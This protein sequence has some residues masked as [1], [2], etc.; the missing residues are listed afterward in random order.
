M[1]L[2]QPVSIANLREGDIP[3]IK[4]SL[5]ASYCSRYSC[6]GSR[7]GKQTSLTAKKLEACVEFTE[8]KRIAR[9]L[10]LEKFKLGHRHKT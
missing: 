2:L 6:P 9:E 8:F 5:T 10:I 7:A 4:V 3:W 1:E